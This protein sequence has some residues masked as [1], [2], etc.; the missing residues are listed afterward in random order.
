VG[1]YDALSDVQAADLN[2]AAKGGLL[3]EAVP[4][5]RTGYTLEWTAGAVVVKAGSPLAPTTCAAL[6]S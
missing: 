5:T 2:D 6:G 4:M 3:K 1:T